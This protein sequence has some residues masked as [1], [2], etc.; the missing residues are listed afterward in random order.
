MQI[1]C[2]H[3]LLI[4]Q[5][6]TNLLNFLD[7]GGVTMFGKRFLVEFERL[8]TLVQLGV[9]VGYPSVSLQDERRKSE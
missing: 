3:E 5:S 7:N 8:A 1:S 6:L 9:S 4:W 2:H